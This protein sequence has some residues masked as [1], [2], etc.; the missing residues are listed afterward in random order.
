LTLYANKND[1][2]EDILKKNQKLREKIRAHGIYEVTDGGELVLFEKSKDPFNP[3][4]KQIKEAA[5]RFPLITK[6][7]YEL[8]K[9]RKTDEKL[10]LY[11]LIRKQIKEELEETDEPMNR[12][13]TW[14]RN[15]EETYSGYQKIIRREAKLGDAQKAMLYERFYW[16]FTLSNIEFDNFIREDIVFLE[17]QIP[18]IRTMI[19]LNDR[20]AKQAFTREELEKYNAGAEIISRF[21]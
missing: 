16:L 10:R 8:V 17:K 12:I 21:L 19:W 7:I 3:T 1:S 2:L 5:E 14:R 15:Q 4:K 18:A 6:W 13:K 9:T 20:Y 11:N